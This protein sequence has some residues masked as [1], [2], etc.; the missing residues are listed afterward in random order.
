MLKR[1]LRGLM[2]RSFVFAVLAILQIALL[3]WLVAMFASI[4]FF[5]YVIITIITVLVLIFLLD[6]DDINPTY[7]LM[8]VLI[9]VLLPLAGVLFYL[10][11]GHRTVPQ[12]AKRRLL[13]IERR[14]MAILRQDQR[15]IEALAS[16]D[17]RGLHAAEYLL[18]NASSPLYP[19][20]HAEYYPLGRD[21]FP[22]FLEELEKAERFI[23][24]QYYIWQEGEMLDEMLAILERKAA[25]GV[26]V[27]ILI[28]SI[29]SM[30]TLAPGFE[31]RFE[32]AG[33][34]CRFFSPIR[35]SVH[36]TDYVMLNHRDHRKIAVV[37]G[38]VGF[39]GGLNISD[40]YINRIERF[41]LWK[42]SSFLISGQAVFSLTTTFLSAW[43]YAA[44]DKSDPEHFRPPAEAGPPR[45]DKG[46]VQPYWDTPLDGEN[47]SENAYLNVIHGATEYVYISTPYLI[48]DHEMITSL[49]LAAKSGVDVRILTPAIPDKRPVYWVT[50]SNYPVLLRGG[51]RIFEYTPGFNHAKMYVSDD[52]VALVGSANMDYRSF[53]LHFEN[54]A[55][56]YGGPMVHEVRRD[57]IDCFA[58]SREVTLAETMQ[59]HPLRR[60][61]Q[62]LFKFLSPIL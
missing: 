25:A 59:T 13:E 56:F 36:I 27:R 15:V 50:Q 45:F 5:T 21:F 26:D 46:F 39:S 22:R 4:G 34:H 18:R 40:E 11:W 49:T 16:S 42:D 48:L 47:V 57:M 53:Y 52:R 2:S 38:A 62:T 51:V 20:E 37:D 6:K 58:E 8:W 24:L 33:I 19:V 31:K 54:C 41:G 28:D 9:I 1:F 61:M 7:K 10:L 17:T 23:F 60:L 32:K 12:R 14:T 55:A 30:F 43:D 44:G 35:P 3:V 29:G